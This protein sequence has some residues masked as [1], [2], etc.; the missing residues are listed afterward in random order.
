MAVL[1]QWFGRRTGLDSAA[2]REHWWID[3]HWAVATE[4]GVALNVT[5]VALN[6]T[7][8]LACQLLHRAV[9]LQDRLPRVV[10]PF[11]RR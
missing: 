2:E 9:A 4:I 10:A 6:V 8:G 11:S 1:A 5:G 7:G 3:P